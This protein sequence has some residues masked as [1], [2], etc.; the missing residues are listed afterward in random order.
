MSNFENNWVKKIPRTETGLGLQLRPILA[1]LGIFFIQLFPN[2]TACSPITY[3]NLHLLFSAANSPPRPRYF[4]WMSQLPY[5]ALALGQRG[6]R[7][8]RGKLQKATPRCVS[9]VAKLRKQRTVQHISECETAVT[10]S[11]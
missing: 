10:M 3:T 11:F 8:L 7:G 5:T 4:I 9:S 1:V 6:I 2:W